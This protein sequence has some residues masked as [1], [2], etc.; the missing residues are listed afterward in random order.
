MQ[1]A[2]P[3][4]SSDPCPTRDQ[5]QAFGRGQLEAGALDSISRHLQSC[6]RCALLL[7]SLSDAAANP[8]EAASPREAANPREA[9]GNHGDTVASPD[10]TDQP[11]V[12]PAADLPTAS[13]VRDSAPTSIGR[14]SVLRVLGRGGFGTVYLARDEDLERLVAIKAPHPERIARP[15]DLD[16]YHR[17]AKVHA[18]VD[19]PHVVPIYDVGRAKDVPFFLVSKFVPGIDLAQRL[20][21][22]RPDPRTSAAWV[23]TLADA[24]DHIHRQGLIHRDVKPRNIMIDA[25]GRPYLMDFGLA[26]EQVAQG[27]G[28]E[29][30]AG[31][32]AYMAP[33]QAR[34]DRLDGRCDVY[35]LGVVLYELLTGE[36]P[37]QGGSTTILNQVVALAP[38]RPRAHN[39]SAPRDL[40]A[41]CLKA[42][43]KEPGQRY[44]S[45]GD[46]GE[47][48][49]RWL[50][51]EPPRLARRV[52]MAERAWSWVRRHP[53]VASLAAV[54]C[55]AA[56]LAGF[57]WLRP[58]PLATPLLK[59]TVQ[60]EPADADVFYVPLDQK[61]GLPDHERG[62]RGKA[63]AVVELAPGFHFVVA[64]LGD[65]RFHEVFRQVP[66][67]VDSLYEPYA[68]GRFSTRDGVVE[69]SKI[70]IPEQ[71]ASAGMVLVPAGVTAVGQ[72]APE[73]PIH[74]RRV[75]AYYLDAREVTVDEYVKLTGGL[76][77]PRGLPEPPLDFPMTRVPWDHAMVYAEKLGKRL[78]FETEY[79]YAATELGRR[80]QAPPEVRGGWTLT[81]SGRPE[82]DR[83]DIPGQPP[84]WGL[85][86]NVAEWTAA[87][88]TDYPV[89]LGVIPFDVKK[90]SVISGA[91][92]PEETAA[93]APFKREFHPHPA[94]YPGLGFR[95]ARSAAPRLTAAHFEQIV[96]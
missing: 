83:I 71:E 40:E 11:Y 41:I 45:A 51:G 95:C 61:T 79:E 36:R 28:A 78:P 82:W 6:G 92:D 24:L 67:N 34:G 59:V 39:P 2:A 75:P 14:Y 1:P 35:A 94:S 5:L 33:E 32:P 50:R 48:L 60:T 88:Q 10:V 63:G 4:P 76:R 68:H 54:A 42:M 57:A 81:I 86:S 93:W 52:G 70:H 29:P 19:H 8:R 15:A 74:R 65:G 56:A 89:A 3:L 49:R 77:W 38:A 55:A 64:A 62:V 80:R 85:R 66:D 21:T 69:L 43:A 44:Q 22:E 46:L 23:A 7:L 20:K 27:N 25:A 9:I 13:L 72:E 58:T 73:L 84:L 12:A 26:K 37:F 16:A 53:A 87:L 90:W 91:P 17:E 31:T 30:I 96:K 47:D 18:G